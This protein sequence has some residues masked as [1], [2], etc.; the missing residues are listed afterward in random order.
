MPNTPTSSIK[1]YSVKYTIIIFMVMF[2]VAVFHYLAYSHYLDGIQESD[3]QESLAHTANNISRTINF[4]QSFVDQ[5]ASQVVVEDLLEFGTKVEAQVWANEMQRLV[6]ESI[7]LSLFDADG[8]IKGLESEIRLSDGCLIDMDRR[9]ANKPIPKPPVHYKIEAFAHFDIV[10]PVVR[11][12]ENIGLVFVSFSLDTIKRLLV[13]LDNESQSLRILTSDGFEIAAVGNIENMQGDI[14]T[15]KQTINNTDWEIELSVV[16]V[17]KN[18]LV[19]S[20]LLSNI[21]AFILLSITLYVSMKK[22]FGIV[23]SDFEVLSWIMS[24]IKSGTYDSKKV[25]NV[26]LN[27]SED[28]VRFIQHTAKEL[29]DYQEK[30]RHEGSTD[31]LTGLYNRRV[32]NE[33]VDSCLKVADKGHKVCL[34]ILDLDFFKNINDTYGHD[35]GDDILKL[36]SKALVASAKSTDVCTRSGGDE[37]ILLLMDYDIHQV[38]EWYAKISKYMDNEIEKYSVAHNVNVKFGISAGCSMIRNND[39]KSTVL[40]RADEALYN[41]KGKG[42][43][44]I[45]FL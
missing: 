6:P 30:L 18:V 36:F 33:K 4:Y 28:I 35:V 2:F 31:A 24:N 40:K 15:L 43:G 22:L 44:S 19:T 34:V 21:V 27:E 20:L 8:Q 14:Y 37:F 13:G 26:S 17:E 5:L 9:F 10:S 45:D 23:V 12:G 11:E 7:G 29:N 32:L 41:A 3:Q 42:R 39:M 1:E 16:D 38:K 25:K